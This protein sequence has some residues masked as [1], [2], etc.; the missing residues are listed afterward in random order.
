VA[1]SLG[2][3]FLAFLVLNERRAAQPIMPRRGKPQR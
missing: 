3:A 2:I 1:L